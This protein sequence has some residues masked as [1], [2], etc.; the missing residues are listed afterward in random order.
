MEA[1]FNPKLKKPIQL[2]EVEGPPNLPPPL[3]VWNS[4]LVW[5][6][7]EK[8]KGQLEQGLLPTGL[9]MPHNSVLTMLQAGPLSQ[10]ALGL[11]LNT[12]RT[13][14]VDLVDELEHKSLVE[15][16]RN[17]N[18][19]RA[20]DVTLTDQGRQVLA[21][22]HQIITEIDNRL[23]SRLSENERHQM[24]ELLLKVLE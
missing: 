24:K 5:K 17:P 19:R 10:V 8:I 20:Y 11:R 15:R 16:R 22:L 18:D 1:D 4:F 3:M 21:E 14:M 2:D 7:F 9:K 12:D 6:T 23:F 13:T